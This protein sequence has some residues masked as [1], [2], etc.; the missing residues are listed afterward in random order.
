[1][2]KIILNNTSKLFEKHFGKSGVAELSH[3]NTESFF[4]ELNKECLLED[5]LNNL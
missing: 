4:E 5:H 1:M 2:A 3:P